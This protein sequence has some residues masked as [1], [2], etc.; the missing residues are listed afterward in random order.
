MH[1][2]K[3]SS[4]CLKLKNAFAKYGKTN[5]TIELLTIA[6]TQD[7]SDYWEKFFINKFDSIGNGYN[8]RDGGNVSPMYGKKHTVESKRKMCLARNKTKRNHEKLN[9]EIAEK[10][11]LDHKIEEYTTYQLAE[12]YNVHQSIIS[13]VINYKIYKS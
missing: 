1:H 2:K 6:H 11:R 13:K 12:M 4:E 7:V 5:F 9:F 3:P 8:I 10:I